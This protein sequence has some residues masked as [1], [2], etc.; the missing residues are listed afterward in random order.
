MLPGKVSKDGNRHWGGLQT[1]VAG[2][3]VV[4]YTSWDI[5][6]SKGLVNRGCL[7]QSEELAQRGVLPSAMDECN[8]TYLRRMS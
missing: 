5:L 4:S 6:H 7:R 1:A 3:L 8:S 2:V